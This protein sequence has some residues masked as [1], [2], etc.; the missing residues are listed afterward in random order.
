MIQADGIK[1]VKLVFGSHHQVGIQADRKTI[2]YAA[3]CCILEKFKRR[4]RL[5]SIQDD[6]KNPRF[7]KFIDQIINLAKVEPIT[8]PPV[9]APE[10]IAV[11]AINI[12]ALG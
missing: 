4:K 1:P 6:M 3:L 9:S 8:G 12:T 7:Q 5:S 11:A 10:I 2:A